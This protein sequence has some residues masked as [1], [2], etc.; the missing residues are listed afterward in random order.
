MTVRLLAWAAL[1]LLWGACAPAP[2]P[3]LPPVSA[4]IP[5][6]E[7]PPSGPPL[8]FVSSRDVRLSGLRLLTVAELRTSAGR[9][10]LRQALLRHRKAQGGSFKGKT[11]VCAHGAARFE[12]VGA[13]LQAGTATGYRSVTLGLAREAV[14]AA[15][16]AGRAPCAWLDLGR[17]ATTDEQGNEDLLVVA[18]E[19]HPGHLV[20]GHAN[21]RISFIDSKQ[22]AARR[23]RQVRR[24]FPGTRDMA[25]KAAAAVPHV[26][27]MASLRAAAAAGFSRFVLTPIGGL[28]PRPRPATVSRRPAV[29]P[30]AP[31][32]PKKF[33]VYGSL[34]K[35]IIRRVIQRSAFKVYRCRT[36]RAANRVVIRFIIS[37]GGS[38][39]SAK[40]M[41]TTIKDP[42]MAACALR[43]VRRFK[44]PGPR[45]GIMMVFYPFVFN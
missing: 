43:A 19:V 37:A 22:H 44:F 17:Q 31:P 3:L 20:L 25:V 27:L 41:S 7:P 11:F 16:V 18:M 4:G 26:R 40:V 23:L 33:T 8:V 24:R 42:S 39:A 1:P 12:D 6:E 45:N 34:D 9:Q 5:D 32:V 30:R 36:K 15:R 38:V 21:Q 14:V 2:A 10:R 29:T 28:D 35:D 13:A